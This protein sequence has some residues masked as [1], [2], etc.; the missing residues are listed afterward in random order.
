MGVRSAVPPVRLE[1]GDILLTLNFVATNRS[2]VIESSTNLVSW[3]A[4][5]NIQSASS[6]IQFAVPVPT[7]STQRFFRAIAP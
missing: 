6:V 7:N 5:T 4:F 2:Y 3:A 1:S